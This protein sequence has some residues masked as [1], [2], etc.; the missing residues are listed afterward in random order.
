MFRQNVV[1]Q[2]NKRQEDKEEHKTAK[3]QFSSTPKSK[4]ANYLNDESKIFS[5]SSASFDITKST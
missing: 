2:Y 3:H 1:N 5:I 4:F